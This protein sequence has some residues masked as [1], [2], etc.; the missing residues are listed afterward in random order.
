MR[1]CSMLG[2][3]LLSALLLGCSGLPIHGL[4]RCSNSSF[5]VS[6]YKQVSCSIFSRPATD[7]RLRIDIAGS[8][9]GFSLLRDNGYGFS[10]DKA[11]PGE[12]LFY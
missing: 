12:R 9:E 4:V 11:G 2:I 8:A 7:S 5:P 3:L 10:I 1:P 6:V